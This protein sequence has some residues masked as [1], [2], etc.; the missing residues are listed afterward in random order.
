MNIDCVREKERE[1]VR[2]REVKRAR[3]SEIKR[4]FDQL[5][6]LSRRGAPNIS[7]PWKMT[8]QVSTRVPKLTRNYDA[9]TT[10][11]HFVSGCSRAPRARFTTDLCVRACVILGR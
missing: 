9:L 1:S 8:P 4:D 6:G 5:G 7:P 10:S 3:V 11:R 2:G